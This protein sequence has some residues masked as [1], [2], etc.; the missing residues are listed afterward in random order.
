MLLI[1]NELVKSNQ[2]FNT[3]VSEHSARL[4]EEMDFIYAIPSGC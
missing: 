4:K 2:G 3:K 1:E